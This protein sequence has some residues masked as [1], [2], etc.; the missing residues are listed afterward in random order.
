MK[1]MN[2]DENVGE[3][4]GCMQRKLLWESKWMVEV[5]GDVPA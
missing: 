5:T 1:G 4:G 3:G 2:V